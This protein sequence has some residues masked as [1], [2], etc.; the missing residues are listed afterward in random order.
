MLSVKWWGHCLSSPFWWYILPRAW[1]WIWIGEWYDSG[2]PRGSYGKESACNAGDLGLIPGLRRS[3]GEGN[4]N[5][6]QYSCL[7]NPN[8]Q[9]ILAGYRLWGRKG[10]DMTE[11][12]STEQWYHLMVQNGFTRECGQLTQTSPEVIS[13]LFSQWRDSN[14]LDQCQ[15]FFFFFFLIMWSGHSSHFK[16]E[17]SVLLEN[18]AKT[19]VK[20]FHKAWGSEGVICEEIMQT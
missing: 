13:R 12:L 18:D 7:K 17:L 20:A 2:F 6:L 11:R 14:G 8:G 19:K 10:S 3:L 4:G 1:G 15:S 5:S 16:G 9:R